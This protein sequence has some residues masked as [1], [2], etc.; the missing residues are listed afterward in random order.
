M[1]NVKTNEQK[2]QQKCLIMAFVEK[3]K[4]FPSSVPEA[5]TKVMN[6]IWY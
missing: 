5:A 3:P 4:R 6:K 1:A 2:K